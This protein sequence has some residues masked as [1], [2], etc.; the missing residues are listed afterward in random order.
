MGTDHEENANQMPTQEQQ[1]ND[2]LMTPT[3]N[4]NTKGGRRH[5]YRRKKENIW[6]TWW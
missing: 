5:N 4:S 1:Q 2:P 6:S 3:P